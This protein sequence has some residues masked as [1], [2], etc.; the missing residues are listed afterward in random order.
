MEA[1]AGRQR[2]LSRSR[3]YR[4]TLVGSGRLPK[5]VPSNRPYK[6]AAGTWPDTTLHTCPLDHPKRDRFVP[7]VCLLWLR[8]QA[9]QGARVGVKPPIRAIPELMQSRIWVIDPHGDQGAR[10]HRQSRSAYSRWPRAAGHLARLFAPVE[11][12]GF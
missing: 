9:D 7:V 12:H 11:R 3:T 4:A 2:R 8:N 1:Q 6:V 5:G 10:D